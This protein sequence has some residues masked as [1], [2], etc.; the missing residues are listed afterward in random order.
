MATRTANKGRTNRP[1]TTAAEALERSV[2]GG[3]RCECE[4]D[5][6]RCRNRA[7]HR[8]SAIC[9]VDG[10][11]SAVHVHLVCAPCKDTWLHNATHDPSA[12]ELRV[13][14]L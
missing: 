9:A 1:S 4:H 11:R 8:V 6:G 14:P 2:R 5:N 7:S 13:T 12:P 3:P 10:C